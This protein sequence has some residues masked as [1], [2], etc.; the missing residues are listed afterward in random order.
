VTADLKILAFNIAARKIT[1]YS[2]NTHIVEA[3]DG[4]TLQ[5]RMA[6]FPDGANYAP[7]K[8]INTSAMP[9]AMTTTNSNY[10]KLCGYYR[11]VGDP[12]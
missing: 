10:Q 1:F 5:V 2:I 8:G 6:R 4:V 7:Q 12:A 9:V 11:R 3:K